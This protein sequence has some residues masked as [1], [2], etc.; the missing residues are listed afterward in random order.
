MLHKIHRSGSR[1]HLSSLSIVVS[2]TLET[3]LSVNNCSKAHNK[4]LQRTRLRDEDIFPLNI[5]RNATRIASSM[6][7]KAT[8][9]LSA[10]KMT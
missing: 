2:H 7:L 3:L 1:M 4:T 5:E 9:P 10:I 8:Q 6:L